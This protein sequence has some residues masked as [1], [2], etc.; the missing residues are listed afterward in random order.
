[1]R[2]VIAD[3]Q[4]PRMIAAL[5]QAGHGLLTMMAPIL[6]GLLALAVVT[7][8]AQTG[9]VIS[10]KAIKPKLSNLSLGKGFKRLFSMRSLWGIGKSLI[11]MVIIAAVAW[12]IASGLV[13]RL[14]ATP[15]MAFGSVVGMVAGSGLTLV[16]NVAAA[17]IV[18]ALVDYGVQRRR[19]H[20]DLMMTK[21]EVK[22]EY[23]SQEAPPEIKGKIRQ[24]MLTMS[25]NRMI[26]NI[27]AADVV[28]VNPT[29][30]AVALKYFTGRGA[31]KVT[32][33]G[34]DGLAARI[35]AEAEKHHV[36]VVEA[37]PLARA[38]YQSCE[39]EQEIPLELYEAV[40]RLL[41]FVH[42]IKLRPP[43]GDGHHVLPAAL[44]VAVGL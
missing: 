40:A 44:Q 10:T 42:R 43:I 32:A 15:G 22:E 35:R 11:R 24:Q 29:H 17:G 27:A 5:S 18:L 20:K 19:I 31:P 16:R 28:V 39:L 37:P 6:L 12:P 34:A 4:P 36:P 13:H 23:R 38:L 1:V 26:A 21:Q 2:E 3:P 7:T 30:V 14:T 33:K 9:L 8:V 41:A 25:R